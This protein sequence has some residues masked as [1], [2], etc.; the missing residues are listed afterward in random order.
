MLNEQ[1]LLNKWQALDEQKQAQVLAFMEALTSPEPK[2]KTVSP[3]G[4]SLRAIR[5]EIVDSGTSL[6]SEAQL[7]AEIQARRGGYQ[8]NTDD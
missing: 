5:Q 4:R 3:L 6:L 8:G 2:F 1:V 7:E